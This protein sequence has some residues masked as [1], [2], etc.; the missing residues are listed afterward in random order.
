MGAKRKPRGEIRDT[1]LPEGRES[2][3]LLD[4]SQATPA[5]PSDPRREHHTSP[6]QRSTG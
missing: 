2:I 3:I 6:L 1:L 4:G 5:R